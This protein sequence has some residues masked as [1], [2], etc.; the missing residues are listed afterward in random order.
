MPWW[1]FP[2]ATRYA[3]DAY[4]G[5]SGLSNGHFLLRGS[6]ALQQHEYD[7]ADPPSFKLDVVHQGAISRF[8]IDMRNCPLFVGHTPTAAPVTGRDVANQLGVPL[9]AVLPCPLQQPCSRAVMFPALL[10]ARAG[11]P[12]TLPRTTLKHVDDVFTEQLMSLDVGQFAVWEDSAH[13]GWFG[14]SVADPPHNNIAH[15]HIESLPGGVVLYFSMA[16]LAQ[17]RVF[18]SIKALLDH[19]SSR[20]DGMIVALTVPYLNTERLT[21]RPPDDAAQSASGGADAYENWVPPR[22][23]PQRY[24]DAQLISRKA[25]INLLSLS[26][27]STG[28]YVVRSAAR[29]AGMFANRAQAGAGTPGLVH[30]HRRGRVQPGLMR[31]CCCVH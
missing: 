29:N 20:A 23:D 24:N 16:D 12:F 3:A 17:Q 7:S 31:V 18:G 2:H 5:A 8:Q 11:S 30:P 15:Y 14:L 22:R 10:A 9:A 25:A 28:N 26:A 1:C 4:L 13:V 6:T 19:H 21:P 27:W